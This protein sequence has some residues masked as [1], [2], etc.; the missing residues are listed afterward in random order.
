[1]SEVTK[2]V[3]E[4]IS[5]EIEQNEKSSTVDFEEKVKLEVEARLKKIEEERLKAE[6][7]KQKVQEESKKEEELKSKIADMEGK[8]KELQKQ[9][10]NISLR[11]S[12]PQELD[13]VVDKP[14]KWEDLSKEEKIKAN[15]EFVSGVLGMQI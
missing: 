15:K 1:M 13:Q 4:K 12:I 6:Q 2:E 10:D 8:Q 9:L 7:E 3:V 11:K 5:E 14:K